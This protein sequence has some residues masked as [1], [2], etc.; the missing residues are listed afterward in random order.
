MKNKN[1]VFIA[2][3]VVII[4]AIGYF[5]LKNK[6][7]PGA[8]DAFAQCISD[9]GATFYGAFWCSACKSQKQAF[10]TSEKYLPY[11]EC[12]TPD[13]RSQLQICKDAD[14]MSYPTWE[15][16]DGLREV[17]ALPLELLSEKTGCSITQ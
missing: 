12:S 10:G 11:T 1:I 2:I 5:V 17:G 3:G 15:F 14:I 7:T 16:A 9:S 4:F 13:S 8:Y 6:N